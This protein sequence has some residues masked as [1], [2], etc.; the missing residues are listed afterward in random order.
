MA[1]C[2]A[3]TTSLFIRFVDVKLLFIW[4]GVKKRQEWTTEFDAN[5]TFS[6]QLFYERN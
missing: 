5:P 1:L 2:V 3:T 4:N 6:L